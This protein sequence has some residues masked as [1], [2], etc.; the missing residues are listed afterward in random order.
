MDHL[1]KDII[2]EELQKNKDLLEKEFGVTRI[3]L[4]GSYARNEAGENSDVDLLIE[5]KKHSF[6]K[7]MAL[8]HFLEEK[9][10][11]KV[12]VGYLNCLRPHVKE[13]IEEEMIC[14]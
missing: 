10:G 6:S 8:K 1:T 14:A 2:L 4:F 9:F 12:D 13:E 3:A 5:S 7:R 11:R